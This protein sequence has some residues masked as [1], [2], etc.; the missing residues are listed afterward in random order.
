MTLSKVAARI[1]G[2]RK[3]LLPLLYGA[4]LCM[5]ALL[6]FWIQPLVA[7]RLLPT[8]GGTPMVWNTCL[9]FFQTLLL[10][11]YAYV[12]SSHDDSLCAVKS[13]ST[14]HYL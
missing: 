4:T 9:L 3:I 8:L 10:A 5:S 2:V 11:G 12:L 13:F 1:F 7:K 6:L 14:S